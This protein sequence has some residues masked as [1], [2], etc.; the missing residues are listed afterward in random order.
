LARYLLL[1]GFS[2]SGTGLFLGPHNAALVYAGAGV[3]ALGIGIV[4]FALQ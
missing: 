3:V 4:W 2:G 1:L